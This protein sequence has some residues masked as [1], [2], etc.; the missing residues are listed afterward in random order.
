MA[1][2]ATLAL[3]LAVPALAAGATGAQYTYAPS[4]P[5]T[6][7]AVTFNAAGS[8]CGT[9]TPCSYQWEDDG[10][11]GAGRHAVAAGLRR[12]AVVHL[13]GGRHQERAPQGV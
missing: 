4:A 5:V 7:Q 6:S 3:A 1:A 11:D 9:V 10:D 13:Q 8:T 12:D 2:G